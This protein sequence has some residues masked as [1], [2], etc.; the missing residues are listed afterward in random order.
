MARLII[1]ATILGIVFGLFLRL[2]RRGPQ[3]FHSGWIG[4]LLLVPSWFSVAPGG[5]LFDPRTAAAL[6]ILFALAL[7][8]QRGGPRIRFV[9][10]DYL[11]MICIL[12]Q[13]LSHFINGEMGPT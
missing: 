8:P 2:R 9:F 6:V 13:V 1:W 10:A 4:V 3:D 7:D 5:L 12:T 11:L